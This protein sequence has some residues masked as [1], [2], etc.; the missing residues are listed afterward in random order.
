MNCALTDIARR[1]PGR[2]RRG[3]SL[4]EMMVALTISVAF[5]GGAYAAYSQISKAHTASEAR[6]VAMRNGRA[7]LSTISEELKGANRLGN[8]FGFLGEDETS[9][10]GDGIDNDLD[11]AV[12][13]GAV[14]VEAE[15]NYNAAADDHHALLG[16]LRE[17]PLHVGRADLGDGH[18]DADIRFGRDRLS[19][20]IYPRV[21][22]PNM[23]SKTITYEL[24]SEYDGQQ[25]VLLRRTSIERDGQ[26]PLE[27]EAPLAF[28]VVGL[29]LLY[30]N[31]NASPESQGWLTQWDASKSDTFASPRLPLPASVYVRLT[32]YADPR[33]RANVADGQPMQTIAMETIVNI[34][35]IINDAQY[36]RPTL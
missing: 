25:D 15:P 6:M 20:R 24:V 31:P 3:F 29:D 26:S 21:P 35:E 19:F 33:P 28:G 17:R 2:A 13:E 36:P 1:H 11:G 8:D 23:R 10:K 5:L 7:A 27:S 18:V 16:D 12:D 34:E 9:A 32:L 14:K 22:T 30:W 4:V